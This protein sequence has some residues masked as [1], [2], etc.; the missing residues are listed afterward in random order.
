MNTEFR[1][2]V[3]KTICALAKFLPS[4]LCYYIA[5]EFLGFAK[6]RNGMFILQIDTK[7]SKYD[8]LRNINL[9][10]PLGGQVIL[11]QFGY[12]NFAVRYI[13]LSK[14]SYADYVLDRDSTLDT[15]IDYYKFEEY[16]ELNVYDVFEEYEPF[17]GNQLTDS[18]Q[19]N[20][21]KRQRLI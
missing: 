4:N 19:E 5:Y 6:L 8:F 14:K 12:A 15:M 11:K 3:V 21:A 20:R 16:S 9:P 13:E 17:Y 7:D 1:T 18:I 10:H 2:K